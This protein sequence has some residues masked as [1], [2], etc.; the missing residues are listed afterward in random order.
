GA[1]ARP[2]GTTCTGGSGPTRSSGCATPRSFGPGP[3]WPP[4]TP[5]SSTSSAR[6]SRSCLTP[7]RN[8]SVPTPQ[9]TSWTPR[10]PAWPSWPCSTGSTTCVNSSAARSTTRPSTPLPPWSTGP[11]S[12]EPGNEK[13]RRSVGPTRTPSGWWSDRPPDSARAALPEDQIEDAVDPGSVQGEPPVDHD[14][15]PVHEAGQVR[16]QEDHHV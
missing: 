14:V 5:I 7:W 11:C 3:I 15:L 1:G 16:A 4:S 2:S 8:R 10:Q 12:T 13:A 6:P 9:V